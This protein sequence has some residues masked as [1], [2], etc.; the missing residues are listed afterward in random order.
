MTEITAEAILYKYWVKWIKETFDDADTS[1]DAFKETCNSNPYFIQAIEE[2]AALKDKD[3]LN[4]SWLQVFN[5]K[6]ED[7]DFECAFLED[8]LH[9]EEGKKISMV[10]RMVNELRSH[11]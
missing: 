11:I 4:N 3:E 7:I 9:G 2:Y 10:R 5:N 6:I 1:M 8:V